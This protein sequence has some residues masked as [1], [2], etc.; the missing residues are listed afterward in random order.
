MKINVSSVVWNKKICDEAIRPM[1][2]KIVNQ[3][4]LLGIEGC[5]FTVRKNFNW[6]D[7]NKVTAL[8]KRYISGMYGKE[9]ANCVAEVGSYG[10]VD[11]EDVFGE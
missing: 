6:Q 9:Y 11:R 10:V 7:C 2:F 8:V 3:M 4:N 5:N 1:I